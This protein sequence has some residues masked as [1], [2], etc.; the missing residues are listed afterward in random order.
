MIELS[1]FT[2]PTPISKRWEKIDGQPVKSPARPLS[3]GLV[4]RANLTSIVEF[5][6]LLDALGPNN[7]LA[8]GIPFIQDTARITTVAK[9][10]DNP[11][12]ITRTRQNFTWSR[13]PSIMMVDYDPKTYALTRDELLEALYAA[14][15]ALKDAPHV[16]TASAGSC[17]YD[18]DMEVSGLRG[19]RVY[20]LVS[21]GSDIPSIGKALSAITPG[22]IDASVY[23]PERLDYAGGAYLKDGLTQRRPDI[24]V[25]NPT[26]T[27]FDTKK[28]LNCVDTV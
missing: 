23:Q 21:D 12:A 19:Q 24:L 27:Q 5:A 2:S 7:A 25:V 20:V 15:P 28:F 6:Y 16:W 8:F 9:Q 18:G 10:A 17:V 1:V 14:I 26:A 13:G 22:L 3:R 4:R 11:G